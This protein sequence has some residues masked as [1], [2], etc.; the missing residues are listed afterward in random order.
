MGLFLGLALCATFLLGPFKPSSGAITTV[1]WYDA[2]ASVAGSAIG[3]YIFI[4]YPGIVNSLGEIIDRTGDSMASITMFLL[5]EASRRLIG[6][7]LVIIAAMFH[8]LCAFRVYVFRADFYGKGWSV[9]RLATYLYLD[10]TASSAR[11]C[12]SARVSSWFS[13][14]LAR[15]FMSLAARSS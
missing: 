2:V 9:N 6:W 10:A 13:S 3:L 15:C 7:P 14:S 11:L 8:F 4:F 12:R 1:P 5:A